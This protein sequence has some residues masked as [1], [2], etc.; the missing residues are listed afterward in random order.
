[1]FALLLFQSILP[2]NF[3]DWKQPPTN[4]DVIPVFSYD[5]TAQGV[6]MVKVAELM[7]HD[8]WIVYD[9]VAAEQ[10]IKQEYIK[11]RR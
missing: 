8:Y 11:L 4:T 5:T 10:I 9:S 7:N 2:L 3:K 1:M 6:H